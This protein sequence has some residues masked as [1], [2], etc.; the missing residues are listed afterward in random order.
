MVAVLPE[1]I[2]KWVSLNE[3]GRIPIPISL[4][5]DN[6]PAL[7]QVMASRLTGDKP[8]PEPM[9]TNSPTHICGTRGC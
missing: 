6:K 5:F 8:L 2:F 1:D 3:N 7:I 4:K 9:M